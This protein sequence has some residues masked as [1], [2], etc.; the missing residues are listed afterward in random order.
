MFFSLQAGTPAGGGGQSSCPGGAGGNGGQR[1]QWP[2]GRAPHC[3]DRS[4][5]Q[6]GNVG[7][8]IRG[9]GG[10]NNA[11]RLHYPEEYSNSKLNMLC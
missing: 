3:Y 5:A 10:G 6:G 4:R 2:L 11:S 9:G 1:G 8:S 7:S